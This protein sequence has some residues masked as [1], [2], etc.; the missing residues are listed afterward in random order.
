M[1]AYAPSKD[2]PKLDRSLEELPDNEVPIY[3]FFTTQESVD[4]LIKF[5]S[6]EEN[7]GKD[8]FRS[9]NFTLFKVSR[10]MPFCGRLRFF[11]C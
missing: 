1:Y 9:K 3:K 6:L 7:K 10:S 8:K 11:L 5:L 4:K 2:Q